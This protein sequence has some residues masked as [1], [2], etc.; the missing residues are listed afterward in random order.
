MNIANIFALTSVTLRGDLMMIPAWYSET[1][2]YP[3]D[4]QLV[5]PNFLVKSKQMVNSFLKYLNLVIFHYKGRLIISSYILVETDSLLDELNKLY[6]RTWKGNTHVKEIPKRRRIVEEEIAKWSGSLSGNSL[7]QFIHQY[8]SI[9]LEKTNWQTKNALW[10]SL[11]KSSSRRKYSAKRLEKL[12]EKYIE[13]WFE[14]SDKINFSPKLE[15]KF[16]DFVA[17]MEELTFRELLADTQ[18]RLCPACEAD[19]S[20]Y[21]EQIQYCPQCGYV[22]DGILQKYCGNC[23]APLAR[24]IK[25]CS[26]CGQKVDPL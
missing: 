19:V 7:G 20:Q 5:V 8:Y 10:K 12:K 23:G 13:N 25:Y 15:R 17:G 9:S 11:R 26:N 4:L 6:L 14:F 3:F 16:P 1:E 18:M 2:E 24:G 22:M 21:G